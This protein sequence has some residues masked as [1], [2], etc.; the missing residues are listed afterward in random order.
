MMYG[1][2]VSSLKVRLCFGWLGF[3][4]MVFF[5]GLRVLCSSSCSMCMWLWNYFRWCK[6]GIVVLM[7]V[8]R[9]GV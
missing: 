1:V 4:V 9:F 5:W 8:C 3:G 6:L 7:C 2:V